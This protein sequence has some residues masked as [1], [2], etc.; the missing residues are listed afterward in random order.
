MYILVAVRDPDKSFAC[1]QMKRENGD[2]V[3][4]MDFTPHIFQTFSNPDRKW[5]LFR[6]ELFLTAAEGSKLGAPTT[7]LSTSTGALE[8][9]SE[10]CRFCQRCCAHPGSYTCN[11]PPRRCQWGRPAQ[12]GCT[13]LWR[14]C[15]WKLK[16]TLMRN[17]SQQ[18]VTWHHKSYQINNCVPH[19]NRTQAKNKI[20]SIYIY[21]TI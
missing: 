12:T 16:E 3:R 6:F 11:Q 7:R 2:M 10:R 14:R 5:H 20:N 9:S 4:G 1:L 18:R 15:K 17:P 21:I 8:T 13:W 19:C